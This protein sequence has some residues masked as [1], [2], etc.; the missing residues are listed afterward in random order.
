MLDLQSERFCLFAFIGLSKECFASAL[1]H[2][3]VV[4]NRVGVQG[5]ER[6]NSVSQVFVALKKLWVFCEFGLT[7]L[8]PANVFVPC[9]SFPH[10]LV[11][12]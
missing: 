5:D 9:D 11:V 10:L 12:S 4:F 1:V 3:H 7:L 6:E 2:L 8:V